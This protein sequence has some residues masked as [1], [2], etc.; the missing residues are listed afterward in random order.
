MRRTRRAP[1]GRRRDCS[2]SYGVKA[3]VLQADVSVKESIDRIGDYLDAN[4]I[5]LRAVVLNA[6]LTCREPF[7][8]LQL[9]DW[10]RG[11]L[12]QRSFPGLSLATD[13]GTD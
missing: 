11:V 2:Q 12:C 7:E 10:E 3:D 1:S 8:Q 4:G 9:A 6:G 5:R 13:C